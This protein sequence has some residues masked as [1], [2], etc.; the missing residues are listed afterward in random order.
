MP[1]VAP[2][3]RAGSVRADADGNLWIL[4]TT[5]DAARGELVYDIVN[6]ARGLVRR[7]R[8]PYGRTIAGFAPGGIVYLAV[9]DAASGVVVERTTVRGLTGR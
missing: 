6:P 4:P 1:D 2:P 9:G 5:T 7:V 3:I 8:L